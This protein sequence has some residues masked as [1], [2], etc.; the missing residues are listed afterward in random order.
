MA[1]VLSIV[2]FLGGIFLFYF[3]FAAESLHAIIFFAGI[4]AISL[5]FGIPA[6]VLSKR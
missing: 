6:H 1:F 5:S 4:I 3:A 2:L